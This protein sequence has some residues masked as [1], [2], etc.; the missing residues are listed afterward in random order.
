MSTPQTLSNTA[1]TRERIEARVNPAN[2]SALTV[3]A[4]GAMNF[5]NMTDIMEFAKLMSISQV[6][7]PK[8][9]RENVGACLA[10]TIQATE[11]QM[12]AFAVAN[13]SYSV[14]DRLGYEAQLVAAVILRRAPIKSRIRY[15]FAGDGDKRVCTVSVTT[16]DNEVISHSSPPFGLITPK[17][18]PLWKSDPD[19]QQGYNTVRSMCRRHFPDVLLGVYTMDELQDAPQEPRTTT[20]RVVTE[21]PMTRLQNTP[22]YHEPEP[23]F[24]DLPEAKP[25]PSGEQPM[26]SPVEVSEETERAG[27]MG[28]IKAMLIDENTTLAKYAPLCRKVGLLGDGVQL[29]DAPIDL[30]RAIHEDRLPIL[31]GEYVPV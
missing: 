4:G 16:L 13:K 31:R 3:G 1:T 11:W 24:A 23:L 7:V 22:I 18:S 9:L 14:N 17:N 20:G 5:Q 15:D 30:L 29:P 19:Q 12:S 27:L 6:A 10:V 2:T 26:E 21:N 8:H 25:G 28:D